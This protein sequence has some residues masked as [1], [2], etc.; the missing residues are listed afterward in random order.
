MTL[1]SARL[2]SSYPAL[3]DVAGFPARWHREFLLDGLATDP[4]NPAVDDAVTLSIRAQGVWEAHETLAAVDILSSHAG[5][6]L[7]FGA[8]V[9]W[10]SILA[11]LFGDG[12]VHA[13][14]N[15][16]DTLRAL[17]ANAVRHDLDLTLRGAVS[18][19]MDP[20]EVDGPVSL[21][22]VDLE[23]M[24][25]WAID[26]CARLFEAGRV[27]AA[28]VEVSPIFEHDGRGPCAYVPLVEQL[29]G[30]GY[31]PHQ[32]PPKSWD[33]LD[34]YREAPVTA[35]RRWRALGADWADVVAGCRQDNFL[36]LP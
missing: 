16:Q 36:F 8:H 24:D 19:G 17:A 3:P 14:E 22:K 4:N 9:G 35:L 2:A 21:V 26:A 29:I 32:V 6:M 34:E 30:W 1:V 12:V 20:V 11:G 13:W 18:E 7:D 23:G 33:R 5:T 28:L 15:D 31:W 25:C 27:A 10:F